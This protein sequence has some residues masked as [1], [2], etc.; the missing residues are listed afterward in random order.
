MVDNVTFQPTPVQK[1][2][3]PI[4]VGG[5]SPGALRRAARYDGWTTGGPAPSANH[6]G[7]TLDEVHE[8]MKKIM[9]NRVTDGSFDVSYMF[10]F[11]E[12]KKELERLV[13]VAESVGVNLFLEGIFG[14]RCDGE[15][16]LEIVRRGPLDF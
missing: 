13:D 11:P 8:K 15:E 14:L 12:D 7:L 5:N 1:P 10:E 3:I 9:E 2:R 4:W 6:L 16:A